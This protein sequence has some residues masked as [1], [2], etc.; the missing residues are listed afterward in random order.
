MNEE[1]IPPKPKDKRTKRYKEWVAKY[2]QSSDGVGDT[3]EKITEATGIKKVVKFL[4]GEDCGCDQRKDKLNYLFP[5]NK[6]N[7]FT[8]DEFDF[9]TEIFSNDKWEFKSI[10]A[11][12]VKKLYVIYNRVFNTSDIPS[13]CSSCVANRLKKLDRLYKEYL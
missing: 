1:Q 11:D 13:G 8:E 5:Y 10:T 9:L 2:E 6:P 4:A 3:V 7:C 12:T